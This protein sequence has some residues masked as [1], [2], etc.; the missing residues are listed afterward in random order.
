MFHVL[1][2]KHFIQIYFTFQGFSKADFLLLI[3]LIIV[4]NSIF[5]LYV[6]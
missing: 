2:P 6:P 4:P 5:I 1:I 3:M